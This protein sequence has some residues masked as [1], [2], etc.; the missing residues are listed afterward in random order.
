MG[1]KRHHHESKKENHRA[2]I[3]FKKCDVIMGGGTSLINVD[4][5]LF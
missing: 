3:S 2:R 5:A 1:G 4:K